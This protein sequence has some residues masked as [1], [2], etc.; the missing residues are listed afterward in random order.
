MFEKKL[1]I[2][3]HSSA[4]VLSFQYMSTQTFP[5]LFPKK[6]KSKVA[7]HIHVEFKVR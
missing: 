3:K 1:S 5:I 7:L 4:R 2:C 6:V